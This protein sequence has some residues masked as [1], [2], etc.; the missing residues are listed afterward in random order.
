MTSKTILAAVILTA[1]ISTAHA[2]PGGLNKHGCHAGSK[3]YHCHNRSTPR[4]S[5]PQKAERV[6]I[7]VYT[8][9]DGTPAY[10]GISNNPQRRWQQHS[11]D[12]RPFARMSKRVTSCYDSR[13]EA[14]R[15]ER[16]LIERN[17]PTLFNLKHCRK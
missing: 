7:Y 3:P 1:A 5:A 16:N 13:Q 6:C 4:P 2:H 8:R 15:V 11:D 12:G 10:I 17:C 9:A 14:L